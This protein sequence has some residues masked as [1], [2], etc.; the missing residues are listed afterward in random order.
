M[1]N[2]MDW[3]VY[4]QQ[5]LFSESGGRTLKVKVLADSVA[6]EDPLPHSQQAPFPGSSHDGGD[7]GALWDLLK[8]H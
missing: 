2:T 6:G 1:T 7:K 5:C 3:V 4:K 8:G